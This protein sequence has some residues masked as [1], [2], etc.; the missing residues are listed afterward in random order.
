MYFFMKM[1]YLKSRVFVNENKIIE[2]REFCARS[3]FPFTF[4]KVCEHLFISPAS[5]FE[6]T[7]AP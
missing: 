4:R 6:I 7:V 5:S 3:G 2:N 1:N